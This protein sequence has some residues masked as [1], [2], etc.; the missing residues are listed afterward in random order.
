MSI[1]TLAISCL[2]TSNL[3]WFMDLT[4]QVPMQYYFLQ[5]QT[6]L[7]SPV[8]S[9]P[10][11]CFCFGSVCSFL[12]GRFL[13][14]PP[15]A[16]WAPTDLLSSFFSVICHMSRP[17]NMCFSL[18]IESNLVPCS[19]FCSPVICKT[20]VGPP[21][22]PLSQQLWDRSLW[23]HSRCSM[24][25][26]ELSQNQCPCPRLPVLFFLAELLCPSRSQGRLCLPTFHDIVALSCFIKGRCSLALVLC[27]LVAASPRTDGVALGMWVLG[28]RWW[29]T[30]IADHWTQIL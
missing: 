3:P 20:R 26:R 15:V 27:L 17:V 5:H 22:S 9:T 8:I 24:G 30:Q 2:T 18:S 28:W 14:S 19:C 11:R 29:R 1:F 16:Y 13:H 10:R 23:E 6:L 4:F 7:P 25:H 21:E 12:L